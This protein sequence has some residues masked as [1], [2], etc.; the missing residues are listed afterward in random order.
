MG[1]KMPSATGSR[2]GRYHAEARQSV[3]S[4][5]QAPAV[6]AGYDAG[7]GGWGHEFNQSGGKYLRIEW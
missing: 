5:D 3:E 6:A 4:L 7:C 2:E 1:T